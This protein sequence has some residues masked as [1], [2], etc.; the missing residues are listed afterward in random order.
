VRGDLLR[1]PLQ[2][3]FGLHHLTQLLVALQA[4]LADPPG[5]LPGS[6]MGQVAVIDV[7][8]VRAQVAAQLA[9]DRGRRPVQ[10]PGDLAGTVPVAAQG[11]DPLAFQQRQVP[12]RARRLGQPDRWDPAVLGPPPVAGLAGDPH[13]PA[14]RHRPDSGLEQLPVLGLDLQLAL[15]S[16]SAHPHTP[17]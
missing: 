13:Q 16:S 1:A 2:L 7:L 14:R 3:Q 6:G 12:A 11:R 5:P 15:A 17:F 4:G 9:A 8:V 10:A